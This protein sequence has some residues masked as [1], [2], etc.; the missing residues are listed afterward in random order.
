MLLLLGYLAI[1]LISITFPIYAISVNY[2]QLE[3]SES[4]KERNKRLERLK[5][6]IDESNKSIRATNDIDTITIIQE[7]IE[8]FKSEKKVLE[9]RT[10]YL[11]VKGSVRKPIIALVSALLTAA[12]GIYF[13]DFNFLEVIIIL[14]FASAL[15]SGYGIYNLYCTLCAVEYAALRPQRTVECDAC[16]DNHTKNMRIKAGK[17]VTLEITGGSIGD[18]IRN[19]SLNVYI[20]TEIKIENV[21]CLDTFV[22]L[23]GE[24][25]DYPNH[26]LIY[27]AVSFIGRDSFEGITFTVIAKNKK[28]YKIPVQITGEGIYKSNFELILDVT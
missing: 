22:T 9:L 11:T 16:F 7:K 10:N 6:H 18:E 8:N 2:L 27:R 21:Q 14:G 24:G 15:F 3:K 23:Q 19:F 12:L 25:W 28:N 20:P 4:E 17:S 5:K 1:G 13:F 26:N